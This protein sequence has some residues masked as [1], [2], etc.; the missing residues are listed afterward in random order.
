MNKQQRLLAVCEGAI[1]VAMAWALSYLEVDLWFQGGSIGITMIPLFIY[2]MR[3]GVGWGVLAGLALGT[4][5][6]FFAGGTA[7]TWQSMLLDYTVAYAAIGFAGIYKGK[8]KWLW[9]PIIGGL[10]RFSIHYLSGITIYA[11]W[12][13]DRFWGMPMTSPYIYSALYNGGYM[14]P[15]I[16]LAV[17][18][19][20]GLSRHKAVRKFINE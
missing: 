16:I 11:V 10:A 6:Y 1:C 8:D 5:K 14:L 18:A 12:M 4:I 15:S 17:A 9:S 3:R 7:L 2:A 20:W 13:P 19:M